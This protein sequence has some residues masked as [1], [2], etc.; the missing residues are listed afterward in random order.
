MKTETKKFIEGMVV[1]LLVGIP[2]GLIFLPMI[3]LIFGS[4]RD[5][6]TG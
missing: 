5:Y 2:L 3:V 1:G 6:L 4:L